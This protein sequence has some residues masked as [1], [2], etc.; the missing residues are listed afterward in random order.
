MN[1]DKEKMLDSFFSGTPITIDKDTAK[2]SVPK[3][4]CVTYSLK[5]DNIRYVDLRSTHFESKSA[6][7][8]YL[9]EKDMNDHP[10]IVELVRTLSELN[11]K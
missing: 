1:K 5:L 10:E 3:T 7:I 4:K 9:I 11:E 8:N 6:F 2:T